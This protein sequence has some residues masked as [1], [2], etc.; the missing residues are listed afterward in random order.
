VQSLSHEKKKKK[1]QKKKE[2]KKENE[3]V[4][5]TL[6]YECFARRLVLAQGQKATRKWPIALDFVQTLN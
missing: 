4:G 2:R 1:K 5:V 6:P 3:P